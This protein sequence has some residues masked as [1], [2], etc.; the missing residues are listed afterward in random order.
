MVADEGNEYAETTLLFCSKFVSSYDG[1]ET[2]PVLVDMCKWLLT[3]STN[4]YSHISMDLINS[5]YV[6]VDHFS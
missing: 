6:I 4:Y 2:H 5:I 1:E 3:V